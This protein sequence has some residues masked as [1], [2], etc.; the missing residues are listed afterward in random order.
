VK[1]TVLIIAAIFLV[2]GCGGGS[3]RAS[4]TVQQ[5]VPSMT[6]TGAI[7]STT[8]AQ[9]T[10]MRQNTRA[11]LRSSVREALLAN[12]HLAIHVL[13][14]N[15]V[16]STALR[17]TGGPALAGMRASARDR[18]IRGL[19]VRMIHDDYR[20]KSISLAPS[21]ATATAVAQ[22]IQTVVPSHLNGD[23]VG[24]SVQLNEQARIVLRRIRASDKFV[25]WR[26]TLLK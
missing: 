25:V 7:V 12:H 17:S 1:R 19:R 24:K 26:L 9:P 11:T 6:T 3:R 22:S 23:P 21:L 18:Q 10:S 16:P 2:G 14:T 8:S 15:R 20:I 13:W 4:T 5:A